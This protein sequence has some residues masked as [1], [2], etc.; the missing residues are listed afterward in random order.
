MAV[1]GQR[2]SASCGA[3]PAWVAA[4]LC[5]L[6]PTPVVERQLLAVLDGTIGVEHQAWEQ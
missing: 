1:I 2:A 3:T 6:A 5:P 4:G